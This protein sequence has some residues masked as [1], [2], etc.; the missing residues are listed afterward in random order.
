[1]T[2]TQPLVDAESDANLEDEDLSYIPAPSSVKF[3]LESY[4]PSSV[5][6]V[7]NHTLDS[8]PQVPPPAASDP[9]CAFPASS[10]E[11]PVQP[12]LTNHLPDP[13]KSSAASESLLPPVEE[14]EPE[15][16]IPILTKTD[17]LVM[18]P[19][20]EEPEF[21]DQA[22]TTLVLLKSLLILLILLSLVLS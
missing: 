20:E 18:S 4:H 9:T 6:S 13:G 8:A 7:P 17:P 21:R 5:A 15:T 12:P 11:D 22:E 14:L 10:L 16:E 3:T 2:R 1:M 19:S